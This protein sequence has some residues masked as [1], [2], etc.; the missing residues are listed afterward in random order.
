[1]RTLTLLQLCT[2]AL[3]SNSAVLAPAQTPE[4]ISQIE[5]NAPTAAP[6][7]PAKPRNVLVFTKTA[8]FRH[9]SIPVGIKALE[10]LG[11]KSGAF[12]STATEDLGAFT[13]SNLDQYDALVMLNTTGELFDEDQREAL[14]GYVREGKGFVGIHAAT[15]C[16]YSYAPYGEMIGGYFNGHP[17][18]AKDTVT[19]KIEDRK[20]PLMAGFPGENYTVTDEIYQLRDPYS[21]HEL[22]VLASLD[23]AKTDMTKKGIRRPDNDFAISW[24]RR[25][26]KGR[27]FYCSLGHNNH[28][29][30]DGVILKHYLAGIQY[31]I[32][33]LQAED[34]PDKPLAAADLVALFPATIASAAHTTYTAEQ[35]AHPAVERLLQNA[36]K[37]P[38]ARKA[39]AEEMVKQ[40]AALADANTTETSVSIQFFGKKLGEI[41]TAANVAGLK[42]L[43]AHQNN[44]A[45]EAARKA[46]EKIPGK[47]ATDALLAA[48]VAAKSPEFAVGLVSSLGKR[49]AAEAVPALQKLLVGDSPALAEAAASALGQVGNAPA[50]QALVKAIAAAQEP[51]KAAVARGAIECGRRAARDGKLQAAQTAFRG[52]FDSIELGGTARAAGLL[53]LVEIDK[54]AR[55]NAW[56]LAVAELAGQ[57]AAL[58]QAAVR[59]MQN[60]DTINPRANQALEALLEQSPS[61][62]Q[63]AVIELLAYRGHGVEAIRALAKNG[64][65]EVKQAAYHAIGKLGG[66]ADVTLLAIAAAS[67][68]Q[69]ARE[70]ARKALASLKPADVDAAILKQVT[71]ETTSSKDAASMRAELIKALV[72][73]HTADAIPALLAAAG[74]QEAAVS[75]EAFKALAELG[76]AAESKAILD[77]LATT[78]NDRVRK[79]AERAALATLRQMPDENARVQLVI[80]KLNSADA[81]AAKAAYARLL[82]NFGTGQALDTLRQLAKS[83]EADLQDAAIRAIVESSSAN[84][85]QDVRD[86]A[87]SSTNAAHQSLAVRNYA[88]LLRLPSERPNSETISNAQ[89]ALTLAKSTDDRRVIISELAD[90]KQA[91]VLD[92]LKP[93]LAEADLKEDAMAAAVKLAKYEAAAAP[94]DIEAML[95]DIEQNSANEGTRKSATE[96]LAAIRKTSGYILNWR[97]AGPYIP[98][99]AVAPPQMLDIPFAPEQAD[100][101]EVEWKQVAAGTNE[102]RREIVDLGEEMPGDN[103]VAYLRARIISK[104]TR[105]ATLQFGS[106]DGARVWL[107]GEVVLSAPATRPYKANDDSVEVRLHE[108]ENY[109]MIKVTQ[110]K[111]GWCASARFTNRKGE[112]LRGLRF[113]TEDIADTIKFVRASS[114]TVQVTPVQ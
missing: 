70:V 3:V 50:A 65:P 45:A 4:E 95:K 92:L 23:T 51:R 7:K 105:A 47:E 38:P 73:R 35:S 93:Y 58:Q 9:A 26:G 13:R 29:Y 66:S 63:V 14:L 111:A 25:Y 99:P 17:W 72:P 12:E 113:D 82:G 16:C 86:L 41:G 2:L 42:P 97:V 83:P 28:I 89:E 101:G 15:D 106:D 54:G 60:L 96:Q 109:L 37:F 21:R 40:L 94:A 55:D 74:E 46:L 90:L 34:G 30:W 104:T 98:E 11:R 56:K 6:G 85:L 69:Q 19:I 39:A 71:A 100:G 1:M 32:G 43:L 79:E 52:V 107:N 75:A 81:V 18:T 20:H 53:G 80:E 61:P 88:R 76:T 48:I 112:P 8:G 84:A 68:E 36:R 59:A 103:R 22:N 78:Q 102:K 64:A 24:V 91:G 44:E 31:A 27:V 108:G 62:R 49:R 57:D 67:G 87:K 33:D 77:L 5:A 114:A 110:G 10:L